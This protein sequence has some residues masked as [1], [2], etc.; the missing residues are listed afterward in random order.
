MF[1]LAVLL[2]AKR[3]LYLDTIFLAHTIT[4]MIIINFVFVHV[5]ALAHLSVAYYIQGFGFGAQC[6]NIATVQLLGK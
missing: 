3:L 4:I 5:G 6:A 1:T 2:C